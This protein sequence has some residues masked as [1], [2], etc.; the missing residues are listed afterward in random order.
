VLTPTISGAALCIILSIRGVPA[1]AAADAAL[2]R[3]LNANAAELFQLGRY[4]DAAVIEQ[5]A[6][7]IWNDLSPANNVE[8]ASVHFNLAQ[9]YL[10]QGKL[11]AAGYHVRSARQL[12]EGSAT[13]AELGHISLLV[14]HVHFEAR[15]YADSESELRA[16]LPHLEGL[17]KAIALNDL[18]LV[19]FMRGDLSEARTLLES[20][21]AIRERAGAAADPHYAQMLANLGMV[22]FR[23]GDLSTAA[24]LYGRAIPLFDGAPGLGQLLMRKALVEYGQVLRKSGRKSEAKA[25]D[26]RARA[27]AR[28][29]LRVPAATIDVR[30]FQ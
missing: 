6:L 8:M 15:E 24:A 29:S 17:E 18:G 2:A 28:D 27:V 14:A 21:V 23:Q 3:E 10:V 11:T 7:K 30:A 4:E 1:C 16:A 12:A 26:R 22:C 9:I 25:V 20:S 19:R 13:P 5:R